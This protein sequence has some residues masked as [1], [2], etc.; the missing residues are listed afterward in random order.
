MRARYAFVTVALGIAACGGEAPTPQSPRSPTPVASRPPAPPPVETAKVE[1]PP[2]PKATTADF[3]KQTL[4]AIAEAV[5][6]HD[7]KKLAG[8]YTEDA[9]V[10]S[11]GLDPLRSRAEIAQNAQK[12]FD[13]IASLKMAHRRAWVTN[14][15]V[16]Y[17][18]AMTGTHSGDLKGIK[19][20]EK[21]VGLS[22][23]SV[24]WLEPNAGLIKEEHR[25]ADMATILSQIGASK[26]KARAVPTLP[27]SIEWHFAKGTPD[28]DKNVEL[29]KQLMGTLEGK[30]EADYLALN[31][32]DV[33]YDDFTM[34]TS[35]K[36]K[37]DLK[38]WFKT[39][40]TAFPDAKVSVTGAWGIE[41]FVVVESTV[42]GTQK[43]ALLGVP[44]SNKSVMLH[45]VDIG[46]LKDGKIARGWTYGNGTEFQ[47]QI[48]SQVSKAPAPKPAAATPAP[49]KAPQTPKK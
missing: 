38:K 39:F 6:Q 9:S 10:I 29:A 46:Q 44:P 28:E 14:D 40:T 21:S 34:P 35:L 45:A 43:G 37:D 2:A 48:T 30:K 41:D 1:P 33:V 27:A 36:G 11:P 47:S 12:F 5:S 25:Y 15:V 8:L 32:D 42:T 31:A 7:A 13:A 4:P 49:Q 23:V 26:A 3:A 20:T 16:V 18:W 19:A 17:E 22:G 24:V